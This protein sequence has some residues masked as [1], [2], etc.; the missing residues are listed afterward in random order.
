MFGDLTNTAVTGSRLALL[1]H[2]AEVPDRDGENHNGH[3]AMAK[4]RLDFMR[5]NVIR[6]LRNADATDLKM[7]HDVQ[8]LCPPPFR[9]PPDRSLPGIRS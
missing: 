7:A 9:I 4:E 3:E 1:N 6:K 8:P 2:T 5:R